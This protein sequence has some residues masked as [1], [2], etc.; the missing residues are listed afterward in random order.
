M[1][2]RPVAENR[3]KL[4]DAHATFS[5]GNKASRERDKNT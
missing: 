5:G 2:Q 4:V 3:T 1:P